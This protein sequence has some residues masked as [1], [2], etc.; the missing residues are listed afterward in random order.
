MVAAAL[1]AFFIIAAYR[2]HRRK[3]EEEGAPPQ[4]AAP[5]EV[6]VG[7]H[8]P[9]PP[10]DAATLTT[11]LSGQPEAAAPYR[12][13]GIAPPHVLRPPAARSSWADAA[14]VDLFEAQ[15]AGES[16]NTSFTSRAATPASEAPAASAS[17]T[18][19]QSRMSAGAAT[20]AATATS[21]RGVSDPRSWLDKVLGHKPPSPV[22]RE[23][24]ADHSS[25][26]GGSVNHFPVPP[27]VVS[28]FS[29]RPKWMGL[30][31]GDAD[32]GVSTPQGGDGALAGAAGGDA[33]PGQGQA[34][35]AGAAAAAVAIP[36]TR[37]KWM[38]LVG[39]DDEATPAATLPAG[40][41]LSAFPP[42]SGTGSTYGASQGISGLMS[43]M[44][45]SKALSSSKYA[46]D[47]LE[48]AAAS[49]SGSRSGS[50]MERSSNLS[51][52]VMAPTGLVA[53]ESVMRSLES[54]AAFAV[55]EISAAAAAAAGPSSRL[56]GGAASS[57]TRSQD[58]PKRSATSGLIR[59]MASRRWDGIS[60]VRQ[61]LKGAFDPTFTFKG[62]I[63]RGQSELC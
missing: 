16:V 7:M 36:S 44:F 5:A 2:R 60:R 47:D 38:S 22:H 23:G 58:S 18:A 41:A 30:G 20:A 24:D 32:D 49:G 52:S 43:D 6:V 9:P 10:A 34:A 45:R 8:E 26:G 12:W 11:Q 50:M 51:M 28:P 35:A 62:S 13:V 61:T 21:A 15:P 37:K 46:H 53:S 25:E 19:G 40:E 1:I 39:P 14:N 56:A 57:A 4:G 3:K 27:T 54:Q 31:G 33:T 55:A 48:A 63:S 17:A 42:E 59:D 29:S